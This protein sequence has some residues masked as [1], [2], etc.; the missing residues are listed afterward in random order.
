MAKF[1]V[2]VS[3]EIDGANVPVEAS[4][5]RHAPSGSLMFHNDDAASAGDQ[6]SRDAVVALFAPGKWVY[7]ARLDE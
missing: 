1:E 2:C 5:V 4:F 3:T 7:F 6:V